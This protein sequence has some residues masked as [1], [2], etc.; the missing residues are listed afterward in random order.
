MGIIKV[1]GQDNL[2]TNV[3]MLL[4]IGFYIYMLINTYRKNF[5][6]EDEMAKR[7][8]Q[9]ADSLSFNITLITVAGLV[10]Y[11]LFIRTQIILS[12]TLLLFVFAGMNILSLSLF[13]YYDIRGN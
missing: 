1:H 9:K 12:M 6:P 11:A 7:N 13:L 2:L 8:Q 4:A 5:E 10:L 3:I